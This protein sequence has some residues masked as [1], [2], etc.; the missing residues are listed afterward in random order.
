MKGIQQLVAQGG[1]PKSTV[2]QQLLNALATQ[3]ALSE[4]QKAMQEL[5]SEMQQSGMQPPQG[6]LPTVA[7]QA[8][9]QLV[10]L[11]QQEMM[12]RIPQTMQRV[13]A[14]QQQQA[15]QMPQR[16][17][18]QAQQAQQGIAQLQQQQRQAQPQRNFRMG[19][20]VSTFRE[21]GEVQGKKYGW[22]PLDELTD[23]QKQNAVNMLKQ[24]GAV[25]ATPATLVADFVTRPEKP[26]TRRM[27]DAAGLT[28]AGDKGEPKKPDAKPT[29]E[30]PEPMSFDKAPE[31]LDQDVDEI[32]AGGSG[33]TR[34]RVGEGSSTSVAGPMATLEQMQQ[35]TREYEAGIEKPKDVDTAQQA[36]ETYNRFSGATISPEDAKKQ[37]QEAIQNFK[38]ITKYDERMSAFDNMLETARKRYEAANDPSTRKWSQIS[39]FLRGFGGTTTIGSGFASASSSMEGQKRTNDAKEEAAFN[40]M[41]E[42]F[43]DRDSSEQEQLM[44]AAQYG[45][46]VYG[47]LM[48]ERNQAIQDM[49]AMNNTGEQ[50]QQSKM[51]NYLKQ[52]ETAFVQEMDAMK[53][54]IKIALAN[55][56]IRSKEDIAR[57]GIDSEN[58]AMLFDMLIKMPEVVKKV[59]E[60]VSQSNPDLLMMAEEDSDEGRAATRKL[61]VLR[62]KA[63]SEY[64]ILPL[65]DLINAGISDNRDPRIRDMGAAQDEVEQALSMAEKDE[66]GFLGNG[67]SF[68]TGGE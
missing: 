68:L 7:Q 46:N 49:R 3:R 18:Q 2:T 24:S 1:N 41:Y 63:M 55:N 17:M 38:K 33:G 32:L 5:Q 26:F 11:N 52:K 15:Q 8:E 9:Q 53:Q 6:G 10:G 14:Q 66:K 47:T 57:L 51:S 39:A 54:Q 25:A 22:N 50:I 62:Y 16:A 29:F 40:K 12:N 23:E 56:E 31:T 45:Q 44:A 60:I 42:V 37:E 19:G 43:S 65:V 34:D 67:F 61:R 4:K 27:Y 48:Q 21:G 59:D 20:I 13:A 28:E 36:I 35:R 64:G 58:Q 30:I